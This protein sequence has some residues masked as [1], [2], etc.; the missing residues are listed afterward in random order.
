MTA[1][2]PQ[3]PTRNRKATTPAQP[4][5]ADAPA[6]DERGHTPRPSKLDLIRNL[7]SQPSGVTLNE[8]ASATGWQQHSV[9]AG[10]TGLR[11]QGHSIERSNVDGVTRFAITAQP[12]TVVA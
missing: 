6:N 7:L 3:R 1:P 9:R 10:M 8:L 2:R 4:I 5:P 11:K 12:A